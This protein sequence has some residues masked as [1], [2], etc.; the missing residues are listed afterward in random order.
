[1]TRRGEQDVIILESSETAG[2]IAAAV[3][4]ETE[5]GRRG[6]ADLTVSPGVS[7]DT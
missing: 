5:E 7:H 4:N 3:S 6:R 2:G 1:L